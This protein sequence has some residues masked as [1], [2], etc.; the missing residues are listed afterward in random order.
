MSET[1][2]TQLG[3]TAYLNIDFTSAQ[4]QI[5]EA[6]KAEGFGVLTEIDVK[7]TLPS[8]HKK[9][10]NASRVRGGRDRSLLTGKVFR[11]RARIESPAG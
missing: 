6:L 5:V 9:T 10:E 8:D 2:S 1:T 3:L 11:T 7:E 4:E